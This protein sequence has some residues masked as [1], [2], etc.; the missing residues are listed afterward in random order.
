MYDLNVQHLKIDKMD[1]TFS[2]EYKK[3]IV[4]LSE[5]NFNELILNFTN[6]YFE[7]KDAYISNGPYD[8]G[9]DLIV[10]KDEKVIKRNVQ[11]TVQ[12]KGYETKLTEDVEKSKDN[13]E[14]YSYMNKLDFYIS[15][16]I[17]PTKKNKLIKDADVNYQINLRIID[18]NELAGLAQ[19][20]KSIRQTIFKFNK[21]AFP[22]ESLNIDKN[23]KILFDTLSMSKDVTILKNNF[24]QS[25][26]LTHLYQNPKATVAEIHKNLNEVFFKKFNKNFFET[27]VGKLKSENKITS[28]EDTSPKQFQLSQEIEE[29]LEQ[30]DNNAEVHENELIY[31]FNEVLKRHNLESET[32]KI[33]DYV[34]NL[35]NAN[36][37]IDEEEVLNESNNHNKKIQRIFT[38]LITQL[39]K[40]DDIDTNKANAIARQLLVVCSKNE[41]L[42]KTSI[43]RMFTNLF[44]SDKLDTYLCTAKRKIY[45][46][47]Q[48]LLQTIC[49]NY[50]NI[51]YDDQLYKASKIFNQTIENS[52]VPVSL[53]TTLGYVEEVAY[54]IFNGLKLERFLELACIKDLGPSKNVF[55]N[56]YL[57]LKDNQNLKIEDFGCFVEELFD[58]DVNNFS[59]SSLV[60]EL[61]QS[62]VE[63][64]E[65][66][67][68]NVESPPRFDNYDK[69]RREYEIAL[70][71]LKNNQKSYEA[72]KHDLNTILYL[73]EMH[74]DIEDGL[75][76]EPFLITWD[77]SFYE[78]RKAFKKFTELNH[79]YLYPPMK[80]ANTISV[81]NM[82]IDS[83]A[84][85]YNIISLVEENFNLSNDSISFL[86]LVNGLF[87][88]SD[89]KKWKLVNKL[90]KLRK[91]LINESKVSD[92]KKAKSKNLPIDVL[93]L[94]IQNFYLNPENN[95][96]Y[97]HLT[98][99]FQNNKYAD[100][101]SG[102]IERN[103]VNFQKNHK[104]KK[105][106]I[107][108]IDEMIKEN[109]E[110]K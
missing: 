64:F 35:Y 31:E 58:I 25:L 29:K 44:K 27:E 2:E 105:G 91:R 37:E 82:Q 50:D 101:I 24:V 107:V 47:T 19:E 22:D 13:V 108:E 34:F 94:L 21:A 110:T 59:D 17:T 38:S 16:A 65:L 75:F 89:I 1:T 30:I 83:A 40:H 84:I 72:R 102:L 74:F 79:Y 49:F 61:I 95:R 14:K 63:R 18:A 70:S 52:T 4:N 97:K 106:I 73:S 56:F 67:K 26:I 53:H 87:N 90:A 104:I 71:Y 93:L 88:D 6:E 92:F 78:V 32:K 80:F 5:E 81:L 85:N 20:Y 51:E 109:N 41:F 68:I 9:L 76:T 42:N 12:K 60:E 98:A 54:H 86:D 96:N 39:Q 77:T 36:Y 57:E 103:L 8:G 3:W 100:K 28:V 23:T 69:Y 62:L 43:S 7:T 66:L 99:L 33:T 10:T 55:F 46:D 45:L 48:I 15:S 11:I